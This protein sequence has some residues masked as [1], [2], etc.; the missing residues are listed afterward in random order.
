MAHPTVDWSRLRHA[1]G[2]AD[3]VPGLFDR[4][5]GGRE[6]ERVWHDL[7][8][9][10][11]HQGTVYEASYAALPLLADIAAGRAPGDRRQAVLMAG[12]IVAEADAARRSHHAS[13]ITELASVAHACLSDVPA[14]EPE[15][16]VYLAQSLLA[17]EGVPV[18]SSRLDLLLEE[19]EVECPECEAA[20][21]VLPG[22]YADECDTELHPASPDGLTGIGARVHAMALGAG[23]REVADW[24]TRLFGHATCPECETRFG[25]SENVIGQ[26]AP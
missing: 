22:E 23:R 10:L 12:L 24:A 16:F 13:R 17:F 25:I 26:A 4:L 6:D 15:T 14:A 2:P 3:D 19:F 8:S 18:W 7:W 20:V 5:T 21:C 11:C 9:A 1:Y